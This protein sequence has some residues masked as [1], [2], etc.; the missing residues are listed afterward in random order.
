MTPAHRILV[1]ANRTCPCPALQEEIRGRASERAGAEVLIVAPALNSSK[2]AHWV[3]DSD[4]AVGEAELRLAETV[5]GLRGAGVHATGRVGDADPF[6]A[7]EDALTAFEAQEVLISTYPE[8]QSHWLEEDLPQ[9]VRDA[10]DG[11]VAHVTSEY[12]LVH[13]DG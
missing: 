12:G 9:R 10:F 4:E 2:L 6:N 7:I 5:E 8:G 3:S 1:V 13:T 11:R